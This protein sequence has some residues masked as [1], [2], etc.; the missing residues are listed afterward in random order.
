[1]T[2]LALDDEPQAL[3]IIETFAAK[4]P[5]LDLR[6]TFTEAFAALEYLRRER[7]DLLFLDVQM[8]DLSGLEFLKSLPQRTLPHPPL[9]IFTTAYAEHAVQ[10]FDLDAVDYLLKPFAL[11]R[12]LKACQ[13]AQDRV[14]QWVPAVDRHPADFL[15]VKSGYEQIRVPFADI[16]YLEAGG[17][18][19]VFVLDGGR[20]I[21]SRLTMQEAVDL[22]P[23][24]QFVRIH[25]SYLV[26]RRYLDRWDR[27]EAVIAGQALPIGP[28]FR[29][30]LG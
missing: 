5:F 3:T 4:V 6:A 26:A 21:A 9:V 28:N 30:N 27:Y 23:P 2:A 16:R 20:K 15:F 10:G 24:E 29:E 12:F 22:L 17:N 25:R 18:Y 7:I 13:K 19:V 8:P 1:M 14:A 11:S